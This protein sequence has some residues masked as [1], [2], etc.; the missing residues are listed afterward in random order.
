M[1]EWAED[2]WESLALVVSIAGALA[3]AGFLIVVF[4][5]LTTR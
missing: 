5:V 4:N 3:V 1:K 2:H